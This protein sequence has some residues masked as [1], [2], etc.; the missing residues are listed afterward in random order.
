VQLL[1]RSF[2]CYTQVMTIVDQHIGAVLQS[3]PPASP[4][5]P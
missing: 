5:T 2:D 4:R 1:A 3:L